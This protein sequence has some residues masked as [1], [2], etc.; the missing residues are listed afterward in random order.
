MRNKLVL[1]FSLFF[2]I[3]LIN[4]T[5]AGLINEDNRLYVEQDLTEEWN[6]I[7]GISFSSPL[8][9]SSSIEMEAL[10]SSYYWDA[11]KQEKIEIRPIY[12]AGNISAEEL[13]NNAFWV[14]SLKKGK[15]VYPVS[16]RFLLDEIQ[17]K[18][19]MNLI[20]FREKMF[21]KSL[22]DV[23]GNC[24]ILSSQIWIPENQAWKNISL[25]EHLNYSEEYLIG[26]GISLKVEKDC[27]LFI[28]SPSKFTG[29]VSI[30]TLKDVYSAGEK[31]ELTDPPENEKSITGLGE[32]KNLIF[33]YYKNSEGLTFASPKENIINSNY[34]FYDSKGA[35]YN[36]NINESLT[37]QEA[38]T[39]FNGYIVQFEEEPTLV[40]KTEAEKRVK[41]LDKKIEESTPIIGFVP[42]LIR[43]V[44]RANARSKLGGL[45]D[46]KES[47]TE[48][49]R[50][51][52]AEVE[53]N[54]GKTITGRVVDGNSEIEVLGE[55]TDVFNGVALNISKE[56]AEKIKSISGV[57]SISPN[58]EVHA[59]LMDSVP[60]I[61]ADNVWRLDSEGNNCAETGKECLTG[62]NVTIAIIDT[63]IDYNHADLGG[64][65]SLVNDT[66]FEKISETP[67][68]FGT[69]F[70][71]GFPNQL[72][73]VEDNFVIYSSNCDINLYNF[74]TKNTTII[75]PANG[76]CSKIATLKGDFIAYTSTLG[77]FPNNK[78]MLYIYNMKTK[79][80]IEVEDITYEGLGGRIEIYGDYLVYTSFKGNNNLNS[81]LYLFNINTR[82]KTLIDYGWVGSQNIYKDM[83][84]F[85]NHG[86]GSYE[87]Y[88]IYNISSG[89]KRYITVPQSGPLLDFR[90][91]KIIYVPL[92]SGW[93][94]FRVY[95]I[96]NQSYKSLFINSGAMNNEETIK[97]KSTYSDGYIMEASL[98]DG[99][100]FLSDIGVYKKVYLYDEKLDKMV[101]INLNKLIGDFDTW[102]NKA[103]FFST[104]N[105][106]YCHY[107]NSSSDYSIK[108]RK[109]NSKVIGGYDFVNNDND[110]MDD[111]GHGTHCAGIAAGNGDGGLKGVAP[112]AKLYA[113]KVL[114]NSGSGWM[115]D[116]IA[117]IERAVDPNQDRNFSD[118]VDVISMSLGGLGN[119]DDA[120]SRT[121][122][123]AVYAGV[124]AV[125]AAG[126]SGPAY[127]TIG[128][129]GT[130]RKAITVGAS[131]KKSY[132][133]FWW[134]CTTP[135]SWTSCGKCNYMN[136]SLWCNYWGDENPQASQIT[137]F[138]SRGPVQW[139]NGI[140]EKPDIVAPGAIIC[141]A[142]YD[143]I[144]PNRMHPYY[145]PCLDESHVQLAGTSMATPVVAGAVALLK[146]KHPDWSPEEIKYSIISTASD[147]SESAF[148]QG[149]G[150]IN[151]EKTVKLI[152]SYPIAY[153]ELE[154]RV[155]SVGDV[156]NARIRAFGDNFMGF[157]I[158]SALAEDFKNITSF[159][160]IY[161]STTP[162]DGQIIELQ[163]NTSIIAGKEI[164]IKLESENNVGISKS[165]APFAVQDASIYLLASYNNLIF[166]P[167][168][169]VSKFAPERDNEVLITTFWNDFL[170]LR[171]LN[172]DMRFRKTDNWWI[173]ESNTIVSDIDNDGNKEIIIQGRI[174]NTNDH[175]LLVFDNNGNLKPGWPIKAGGYGSY[176]F[177]I[178][179]VD[180]D[181]DGK[182]EILSFNMS[183]VLSLISYD[184]NIIKQFPD[185]LVYYNYDFSYIVF[186]ML[187]DVDNDNEKEIVGFVKNNSQ[188]NNITKIIAYNLDG[189][190]V[191]GWPINL[192]KSL[193]RESI[194]T[195]AGDIDNDNEIEI[196]INQR[197]WKIGEFWALGTKSR[198]FEWNASMNFLPNY[199][200]GCY[201]LFLSDLN[202]DNVPEIVC[203]NIQ[204]IYIYDNKGNKISTIPIK[205]AED[206]FWA[207]SAIATDVNGDGK[208]ELISGGDM[209]YFY[210]LDGS[211]AMLP[212]DLNHEG[213][214][215]QPIV[216]DFDEDGKTEIIVSTVYLG[217]WSS[218]VYLIDLPYSYKE[219]NTGWPYYYYDLE[220]S[221]CYRC[222][223]LLERPQSKIVNRGGGITGRL[224][225][226][227]QKN[228]SGTWQ[229]YKQVYNQQV[230][231]PA[232][233][234]I[235]LDGIFN[236][237]DVSV[238]E[239][240]DYRVYAEFEGKNSSFSFKV[241]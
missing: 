173:I 28:S 155:F 213:E 227:I 74:E 4:F 69:T 124:V 159:N 48:E 207:I 46:Y 11:G 194:D 197:N 7:S 133:A 27:S 177:P 63:G 199:Y 188:P 49:H 20:A 22:N 106:I 215:I 193:Q 95:D 239:V 187:I 44:Q 45:P 139:A 175:Y 71:G 32:N 118:H 29:Y 183:N 214:I 163:I 108:E 166:N 151:V 15:I 135:S 50:K 23:K 110:P 140:L 93:K 61:N 112:D 38:I 94:E 142:R 201:P 228:V 148:T 233:G 122:D 87:K 181:G 128:S 171:S 221:R 12:G 76:S 144:Y 217:G 145:K 156:V 225:I 223:E 136:E 83:I 104:D 174:D 120:I 192:P 172:G 119:P 219:S 1:I 18:K 75:R 103:C 99:Y 91:G 16:S 26:K 62:K 125:I 200:P 170:E 51:R 116:V 101:L 72:I 164:I 52:L 154:K 59:T 113:Y 114:D 203:N 90:D 57:K 17:L 152:E 109:F 54:L 70:I 230:S 202:N 237:L 58:F 209:L 117:G 21:S 84:L 64:N 30:A 6:I 107:Y 3:F 115:S 85:V 68:N 182:K 150:A 126:N 211:Y 162:L 204:Y 198:I 79:E 129:P 226:K 189:T 47:L 205:S 132:Q 157:K 82:E 137:A 138:S 161:N 141:S 238:N 153:I 78:D 42:N 216:G 127:K 146:Q 25:N 98:E 178:T 176:N 80:H 191:S 81:S 240:G 19:G 180:S 56:E 241:E 143:S 111:M 232:K 65:A 165:Y 55:F 66:K 186:P 41:E 195:I 92:G 39:E 130:A 212:I 149:G 77:N 10:I 184:G 231:I 131:Y 67:I 31:I 160:L 168:D 206:Y 121:V 224:V 134:N 190:P 97:A 88:G 9:S 24:V 37:I 179:V 208:N 196:I 167:A 40:R 185:I 34:Y 229:D 43:K 236:P 2:C 96:V 73:E 8:Y 60:L 235:K 33:D 86:K 210:N 5:S 105:Q 234:V 36:Y 218:K 14:Y 147:L 158:Y 13:Y 123:N 102:N 169:K 53:K 222:S 220:N 35:I 89:E 100:I